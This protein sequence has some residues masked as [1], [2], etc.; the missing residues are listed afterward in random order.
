METQ[1]SVACWIVDLQDSPSLERRVQA[2]RHLGK[3]GT[4]A[5]GAITALSQA[6]RHESPLLRRHSL[7]A[8]GKMGPAA[9]PAL[10]AIVARLRDDDPEV[11]LTARWA[12]TRI[13]QAAAPALCTLLVGPIRIERNRFR[14]ALHKIRD[15]AFPRL[16]AA[17]CEAGNPVRPWCAYALT[18][19]YHQAP[20]TKEAIFRAAEDE[21]V[22]TRAWAVASLRRPGDELVVEYLRNANLDPRPEFAAI[23]SW[24]FNRVRRAARELSSGSNPSQTAR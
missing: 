7:W 19:W 6:T 18:M 2:A 4:L 12:L 15:E 8:L 13:G 9:E 17:F 23:G 16:L 14:K 20:E 22:A 11:A 10:D 21:D 1:E 24:A 5:V 3:C